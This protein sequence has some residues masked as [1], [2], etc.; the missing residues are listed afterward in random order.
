MAE[1]H[2]DWGGAVP[3]KRSSGELSA[4][5]SESALALLSAELHEALALLRTHAA[6]A[7]EAA[8][9]VVPQQEQS[10][11]LQQCLDL[12]KSQ[13]EAVAEPIRSI[14]HF[15][16][17]GGTLISKCIAAM[18][19]VQLLSEVD[20]F[21]PIHA[22]APQSGA[23]VPTDMLALIRQSSRG[24]EVELLA[25]VFRGEIRTLYRYSISRGL[26]VVLRDHTHGQYCE[27]QPPRPTLLQ[28][29]P[30]EMAVRSIVTVRHPLESWL[31]LSKHGW[32]RFHPATLDEY[33]RRYI[34]FL[35]A[36][37]DCAVYRYEDFVLN[38]IDEMQRI[39]AALE[40]KFSEDFENSF[41]VF[42]MSGDSGR[43][44]S[45][46]SKRPRK[47]VPNLLRKEANMS[48]AYVA[49]CHRLG[50]EWES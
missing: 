4:P 20:P 7:T 16:C 19:N 23:F 34:K 37:A 5:V 36:H 33:C 35:D 1:S 8:S 48:E 2:F 41:S 11:L 30:P 14:H 22:P 46:I 39:C 6:S 45:I 44:E 12:L 17:T 38:P 13:G 43:V 29:L 28:I 32:A 18:P 25:E 42:K 24:G 9:S 40:L 27:E 21:S 49:L 26:H 47:A 50:Y 3:N 15:A 10:A 31:S